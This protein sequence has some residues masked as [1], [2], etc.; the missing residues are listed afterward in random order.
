M[1][2]IERKG[3]RPVCVSCRRLG[4]HIR[5]A[6]LAL[7]EF[8]E[9]KHSQIRGS[10]RARRI[11]HLCSPVF[12]QK[13]RAGFEEVISSPSRTPRLASVRRN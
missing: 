6:N 8:E 11:C 13:Q 4:T 1:W 5:T 10:G 7:H 9:R 12:G 3:K 2:L